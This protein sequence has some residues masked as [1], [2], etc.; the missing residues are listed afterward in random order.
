MGYKSKSSAFEL[1]TSQHSTCSYFP[2]LDFDCCWFLNLFGIFMWLH[3]RVSV[4]GG[5]GLLR[6]GSSFGVV[7]SRVLKIKVFFIK[8]LLI[9][10]FLSKFLIVVGF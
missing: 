2:L 8:I 7:H 10:P 1:V 9:L 5:C 3:F 4:F 6:F